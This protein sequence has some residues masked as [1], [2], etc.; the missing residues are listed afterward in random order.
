MTRTTRLRDGM[1]PPRRV[2]LAVLVSLLVAFGLLGMHALS[3][4]HGVPSLSAA[5]S[6]QVL[7][8]HGTHSVEPEAHA[9]SETKHLN[10]SPPD[11]A[12]EAC[13]SS[14]PDHSMVMTMCVIA[15]L[16]A[17]LVLAAPAR[18]GGW[19]S[20]RPHFYAGGIDFLLTKAEPRPPSLHFLSIS[21]T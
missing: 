17:L 9:D 1:T 21:R 16:A 20:P 19:V 10:A 14:Y 2:A 4:G 11:C 12:D 3:V 7:T 13:G 6:E 8:S 5:T 18:A 15:L